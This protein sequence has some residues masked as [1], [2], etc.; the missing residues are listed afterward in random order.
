MES[1]KFSESYLKHFQFMWPFCFEDTFQH[2]P[3]TDSYSASPLFERYH[4]DLRCWSMQKKFFWEYPELMEDIT[5]PESSADDPTE[6]DSQP[7][8]DYYLLDILS[9]MPSSS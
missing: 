8:S 4:R 2:C 9:N 5:S 1:K 7:Q 6:V 3:T